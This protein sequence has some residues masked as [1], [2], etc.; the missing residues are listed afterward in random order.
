MVGRGV[1]GIISIGK[2]FRIMD[3]NNS[4]TLDFNEFR[5]ASKDY[6]WD[7]SDREVEIAFRAFN[8]GGE[9]EID[10]EE[11]LRTIRGNM[12]QFRV[13]LCEQ[14]FRKIDRDGSGILTIDDLRGVY[15]AKKHPEVI[16]GRKTEDEV[17]IEYLDTFEAHHSLL[18][19]NDAN[20]EIDLE[21]WIEYYQN[22][23]MSIDDDKYFE[24]MMNNCWRMNEHTT[25]NN[26]KRGWSN[27]DESP[28]KQQN[29]SNAYNQRAGNSGRVGSAKGRQEQERPQAG[30]QEQER[31]QTAT[32]SAIEKF[33][34]KLLSR[35]AR[36]IIGISR[37]FKIFD[38]DNSKT[39]DFEE[40][41][42]AVK[43]FRVD[44]TPNEIKVV[45]GTFDR[46]GQG[47][48]DYDEFL[49]QIRGEM[50]E[51]RK[52]IA[53]QAF[54][55]MDKD[56]NG[57]L[58]INDIK[59]VYN[60]KNHPEVRAGKKSEEEVFGEF[61]ETFET[62][63]NILKGNRDRRVTKDE[64]IEYYNNVSMSID[65]DGY[66]ETMMVN[67]WKLNGNVNYA[68]GWAGDYSDKKQVAEQK[69]VFQ[70]APFGVSE[71]KTNYSTSN[72]QVQANQKNNFSNKGEE[73]LIR[74]RE[75]ISARGT[76]GIFG[77][78]RSFMIADDNHSKTIDYNEF[79]K[80][81]KDYRYELSPSDVKKLFDIFDS[82]RSGDIDYEEFLRSIVGEMND[83]RKGL[84][85]KAFAKMDKNNNG[86]LE[87]DDIKG[88]YNAKKCPDVISGKKTEDEVLAE[89]LDTFE[90][91][92]S[93][94]VIIFFKC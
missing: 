14:A 75:K 93:L 38:D 21:E 49:R 89:F 3:D 40:F 59:Y 85:K 73:V 84:A 62:H 43:D 82:N 86:S 90:Y 65:D 30:R 25:G 53:L 42:K 56:G 35:G 8:E 32:N 83:F 17:F 45:F 72:K 92:F 55:K 78:R 6:R 87:I 5:K 61:L 76:R 39:I 18:N 31:P 48:I 47:S 77:I 11:F 74:F 15:N 80:L 69:K 46:D 91:H 36:G 37:Q 57:V 23:S 27:K 28:N 29:I 66:F 94:L 33:R 41:K 16:A 50:N 34:S 24:V 10:Y 22:V 67:A 88:T 60:A 68:K 1:R 54:D 9:G 64:W 79:A 2:A 26:E 19:G 52:K 12:N 63:H 81:V 7:L 4:R 58:E 20:H 13:R 71:E 70:N 44:L 51:R